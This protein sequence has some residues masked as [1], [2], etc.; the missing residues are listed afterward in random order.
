MRSTSPRPKPKSAAQAFPPHRIERTDALIPYERNPRTHS[1]AQ[2]AK[3]AASIQA[4][5]FT[6]PVLVDG[7]RGI[8]AGHGRV[9]AA[10][11]LGLAEL[12]VIELSHLTAAQRRAYVMADNRLAQDGGWDDELLRL[13]LGEL[14]SV[15]FDVSLIGFSDGEMAG[16]LDGPADDAE[17]EAADGAGSYREQYG[18]IAICDNEAHQ[19]QVF[20]R[21]HA[22]GLNVRVVAT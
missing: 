10:Q 5:G 18:V 16:F 21:L 20:E 4:F 1:D 11:L 13:E 8:I 9:R 3:I 15:A 6:N 7:E 12:P 17:R 19:Q 2:V 22:E 14:R